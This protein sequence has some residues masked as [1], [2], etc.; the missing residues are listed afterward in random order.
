MSGYGTDTWCGDS[1]VTGRL[2][3][4]VR[5]VALAL[6]R[7]LITP[8]GTLVGGDDESAYGFDLASYVGAVG[9]PVAIAALPSIVRGELMKDERVSDVVVETLIVQGDDG[10]QDIQLE[11]TALLSD[12]SET[13]TL[14]LAVDDVTTA[15]VGLT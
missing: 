14:V 10:L 1:L 5:L 4:G 13:F 9:Y 15:I 12:E 7:R 2:A 8:R 11:V 3:K 6:Y